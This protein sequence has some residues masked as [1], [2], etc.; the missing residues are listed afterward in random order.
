M[1]KPCV[2]DNVMEACSNCARASYGTRATRT[3]EFVLIATPNGHAVLRPELIRSVTDG[4]AGHTYI[5][6]GEGSIEIA[7]SAERVYRTLCE[8]W[9]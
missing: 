1:I 4:Q 2:D 3:A 6:Y 8:I 7:W 9:Q 5:H